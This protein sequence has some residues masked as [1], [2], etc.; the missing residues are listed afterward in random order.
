VDHLLPIKQ[1][2]ELRLDLNNL[3]SLCRSCH[4]RKTEQDNRLYGGCNRAV[5]EK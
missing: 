4:R 3:Q 5:N 1:A 2:P